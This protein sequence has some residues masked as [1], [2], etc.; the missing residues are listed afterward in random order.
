MQEGN[1][2]R[3]WQSVLLMLFMLFFSFSIYA[4]AAPVSERTGVVTD[5]SG[6]FT[7]SQIKQLEDGLKGA[8]YE[9]V[10]LTAHGL[11]EEAIQQLGDNAYNTWKLGS[12]QLLLLITTDPSSVHLVYDNEQIAE[13]VSRSEASNSQGIIDFNYKPLAAAGSP[14]EGIIAVSNYVNALKVPLKAAPAVPTSP[15]GSITAPAPNVPAA[16]PAAGD[17]PTPTGPSAPAVPTAPTGDAQIPNSP[18]SSEGTAHAGTNGIYDGYNPL[19][20]A[21]LLTIAGII[22]VGLITLFIV[23]R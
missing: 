13:A 6:L 21:T 1:K 17:W 22:L 5:P 4:Y 18:P 10:V 9:L 8:S 16:P 14:V 2:M 23:R 12:H 20:A 3:K 19:S 7:A 11:N 15:S